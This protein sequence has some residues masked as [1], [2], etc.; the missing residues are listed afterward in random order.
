MEITIR[1]AVEV[2]GGER[3]VRVAV[4]VC[5]A[6][7]E[8]RTYPGADESAVVTGARFVDTGDAVS[9]SIVARYADRWAY[10]ALEEMAEQKKEACR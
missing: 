7:A 6:E 4:D 9:A 2:D 10:E 8:T 1:D 3:D 5:P